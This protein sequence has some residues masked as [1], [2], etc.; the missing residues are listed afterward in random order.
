[1]ALAGFSS[2]PRCRLELPKVGGGWDGAPISLLAFS[3]GRLASTVGTP[4][5]FAARLYERLRG[6]PIGFRYLLGVVGLPRPGA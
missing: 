2:P 1:M 3:A 4:L 5:V 6:W